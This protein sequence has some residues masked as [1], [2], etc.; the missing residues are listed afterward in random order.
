MKEWD[1]GAHWAAK[2]AKQAEQRFRAREFEQRITR[3]QVRA[4]RKERDPGKVKGETSCVAAQCMSFTNCVPCCPVSHC[5]VIHSLWL[6]KADNVKV[7]VLGPHAVMHPV[8]NLQS[9]RPR[10]RR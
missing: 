8:F 3:E 6:T 7:V 1:S 4:W 10:R 5:T 2:Q 9:T